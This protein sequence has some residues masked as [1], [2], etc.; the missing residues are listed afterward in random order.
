MTQ[1]LTQD[2]PVPTL[3]IM[4]DENA[5]RQTLMEIFEEEGFHVVTAATAEQGIR[6]LSE[7]NSLCAAIIDLR[8]PD[9]QGANLLERLQ[10][11]AED[12]PMVINTAYASYESVKEAINIG[13]FAYVEKAGDPDELVHHVHRAVHRH[14]QLYANRLEQIVNERTHTLQQANKKL[15]ESEQQLKALVSELTLTEERLK[16]S[17]ATEMHDEISQSLAISRMKVGALS[18]SV[19]DLS[20][21]KTLHEVYR[22]LEHALHE[23]RSLT[24][25]LSY[26]TLGL[27]GFERAIAEWLSE[28]IQAKHGIETHFHDDGQSKPLEEDMRAVLFRTIRELLTNAVKHSQAKNIT[29]SISRCEDTMVVTVSDDGIG[30]D[31]EQMNA[32]S[33]GFGLLSAQEALGCLGGRFVIESCLGHGC[34][35]TV[36]APLKV[37]DVP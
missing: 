27:L 37:D 10:I 11:Y 22:E 26:P 23:T 13:A 6:Y 21:Q 12:V 30:Y 8:L 16:R 34:K 4:E 31:P 1:T 19:R 28:E 5:L 32:Q 36:T 14:L 15:S 3:L 35:I 29:V 18:E 20:V 17:I 2:P 7:K 25:R 33:K 9:A 24:S